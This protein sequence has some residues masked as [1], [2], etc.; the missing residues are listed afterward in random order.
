MLSYSGDYTFA[1]LIELMTKFLIAILLLVAGFKLVADSRAFVSKYDFAN[2]AEQDGE[3]KQEVK[4]DGKEKY[5]K[6]DSFY[7]CSFL[8]PSILRTSIASLKANYQQD[9]Y[10]SFVGKPITPPP[11]IV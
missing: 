11:N 9:I 6:E 7:F 8:N 3:G 4:E 5:G 2:C 10:I 1:Q